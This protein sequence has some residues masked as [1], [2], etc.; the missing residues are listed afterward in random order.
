MINTEINSAKVTG[1]CHC[2]NISYSAEYSNELATYIPRACDCTLCT[3]H[4]A[5]YTSDRNGKLTINIRNMSQVNWYR[6]GSQIA[7][8]LICKQC[9][10]MTNVIYKEAGRIYGSINSRTSDQFDQF[11]NC[12]DMHLTQLSDEARIKRWKDNWFSEVTI[13]QKIT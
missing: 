1:G 9:G 13:V 4:G 6:Q 10:I 5:A 7:D 3:R 2:G 12:Q 8:F 11:G